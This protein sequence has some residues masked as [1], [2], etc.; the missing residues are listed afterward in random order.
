MSSG[1][2]AGLVVADFSRVLA[3]PYAT[4]MLADMGAE[5]IKIERPGAGDDTRSW[6]PPYDS[7][8][9][10]TYFASVNRNKVSHVL[11]L[12]TERGI[13]DARG[14]ISRADILIENFRSGTMESLG[15]GYAD[16]SAT[17]PGLIYCS[18]TGFGT[19]GGAALPGYD[20]LVQAMGGLMSVTG[21][22]AQT[23]TKVGVAMVD[24]VTG[25]HALAGI[26]AALHHRSQSGRGQYV[27]TS[28]M[29]CVLSALSNQSA[30]YLGSGVVPTAMGNKHP[31]VVP[32]EVFETADRPLALAVGND[33]QFAALVEVLGLAELAQD[34]RFRGNS[35]RVENRDELVEQLTTTFATRSADDWY[36][37][38]TERHVPAGP[39]NTIEEAFD[40]AAGI[41]LEP[42]VEVPGAVSRHVRN[43]IDFSATPVDYRLPP[44]LLPG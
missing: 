30:A 39:V 12:K 24:I 26:L 41:G 19:G 42:R 35:N 34:V 28:L 14:I 25:L 4:M 29:S 20:L 16:L 3:G 7:S 27:H 38:L 43:P 13:A 15:L 44:P 36:R 22:D 37:A 40:F 23:P 5:V 33:K 9:T 17:H 10:A 1:P 6:G 2:L 31:S 18:I 32:Y 11:D 21:P 8:G